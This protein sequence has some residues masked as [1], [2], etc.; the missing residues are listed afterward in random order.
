MKREYTTVKSNYDELLLDVLIVEPQQP[1][2]KGIIQISHGMC[3][4]KER[5]LEFMEYMASCGYA[6]IIHDHRGHGHSVKEEEH[7]GYMYGGGAESLVMDLLQ[8]THLAK[9]RWP[10][11]PLI[12]LGHSM[13][14]LI[15]RVYLKQHDGQLQALILSGSPSK[16]AGI[17]AGRFI[18]GMQ[19]VFCGGR[20]TSKLLEAM[21]FGSYVKKFAG[22]KSRF[23]WCCSDP[24]VVEEY[25]ESPTCGFP[26]TVDG[27]DAL[28]QLMER[29]Y[30][31]KGWRCTKPKLP[32]LFIGGGDDPC[33]NGA[34]HLKRAIDHMRS[35]GYCN[36]R[37]KLYPGKRHEILYETNKAEVYKDIVKYLSHI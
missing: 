33:I 4:A 29:T 2:L 31:Y 7:L 14:S 3:E 20:H 32:I 35:V 34:E 30:N 15:A 16:R 36:I 37:G 21:T 10:Q 11:T 26:F 12:M 28:F 13:G 18:D 19:R 23:A 8:V 24:K 27:Y 5:Y 22:E 1:S 25:D 17:G 9:K 6:C